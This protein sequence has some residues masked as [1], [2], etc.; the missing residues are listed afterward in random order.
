MLED[1][2]ECICEGMDVIDAAGTRVG[3]VAEVF[4]DVGSQVSHSGGGYLGVHAGLFG[5][6]LE[7][8]IPFAAVVRVDPVANSVVL[9]VAGKDLDVWRDATF[10]GHSE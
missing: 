8:R 2:S 7:H 9:N 10:G 5:R 1:L 3:I 6:G 4:E